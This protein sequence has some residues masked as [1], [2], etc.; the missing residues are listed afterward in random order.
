MNYPIALDS[1]KTFTYSGQSII[2]KAQILFWDEIEIIAPKKPLPNLEIDTPVI[3]RNYEDG[4]TFN[5][6]FSHFTPN[7]KIACFYRGST[8]W[9]KPKAKHTETSEWDFWELAEK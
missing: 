1:D 4:E 7:G 8:S 3:V 5:R 2:G 6:Y 9:S